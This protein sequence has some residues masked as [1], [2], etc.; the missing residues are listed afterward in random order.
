MTV[1]LLR[2]A[3]PMQSWGDR[4]RFARRETRQEPTKSGVLG[5]L[6]AAEGR[7]RTDD[8]E[9]L[10][11]T[12]F[13]VRIDQPGSLLRDF[14]TA[15]AMDGTRMPVSNRYYLSDAVF[16]AAI[17]GDRDLLT[18]LE[19]AVRAPAFPLF[20]GRRSC[21]P[22]G[23][24]CLGLRETGLAAALADEPWLAAP[25]HRR[26]CARGVALEVVRDAVDPAEIGEVVRDQ[27]LSWD[28]QRREYGW[29]TVVRGEPV[30][31]PN[32]QLGRSTAYH[33]PFELLAQP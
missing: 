14:H 1:L 9:D 3:A 24:L 5:M 27:P 28:P 22:D 8:I 13:G 23:L 32:D 33:D 18:G 20:L 10:A 30:I 31:V 29:R 4:S 15:H 26:T 6:A 2:L 25:W 7:R 17:E 12:R 11:G 21:P 19:D 16:L